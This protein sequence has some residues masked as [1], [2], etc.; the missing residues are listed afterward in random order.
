M[1]REAVEGIEKIEQAKSNGVRF[2]QLQF[3]DIL[4]IVKAVTI[5]LHQMEGSVRHGT[6]FDGSSI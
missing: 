3:T 6:W 4:G 1:V 5:P 2:V